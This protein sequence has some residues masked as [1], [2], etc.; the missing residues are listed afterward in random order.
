MFGWIAKKF[1]G[2]EVNSDLN[3]LSQM[4]QP[5]RVKAA[6]ATLSVI[7]TAVDLYV[8]NGNLLEIQNSLA[9]IRSD[10]VSQST[11]Y[12]DPNHT[13]GSLP[14]HFF[15]SLSPRFSQSESKERCKLIFYSLKKIVDE[16]AIKELHSSEYIEISEKVKNIENKLIKISII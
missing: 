14:D 13:I 7:D 2:V 9:N 8:K 16:C 3:G 6:I 5:L 10:K 11:G 12:N 4:P 1:T 15:I